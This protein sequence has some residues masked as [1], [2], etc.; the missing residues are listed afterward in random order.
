MH[1]GVGEQRYGL[2]RLRG[3]QPQPR[4][5]NN[6]GMMKDVKEGQLLRLDAG[7]TSMSN[8]RE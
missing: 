6:S 2:Q 7:Q 3:V 8:K 5:N 1:E 4:H